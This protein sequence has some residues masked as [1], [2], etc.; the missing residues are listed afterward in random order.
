MGKCLPTGSYK[1]PPEVDLAALA[2]KMIPIIGG[3]LESFDEGDLEL[4]DYADFYEL[5]KKTGL[6]VE[7][8]Y[9]PEV[10]GIIDD[11]RPGDPVIVYTPE[12]L[13]IRELHRNAN[14][15]RTGS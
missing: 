7:T 9:N 6:G 5:L 12:A 14:S 10:D 2:I 4:I 11:A 13:Q 1:L 15:N 3:L 8:L